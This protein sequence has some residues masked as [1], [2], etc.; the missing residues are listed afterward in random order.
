MLVPVTVTPVLFE[1]MNNVPP[2]TSPVVGP[3]CA[4]VTLATVAGIMLKARGSIGLWAPV[5]GI[6][7]GSLVAAAFGVYDTARVADAPWIGLPAAAWP[8]IHF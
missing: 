8:A 2:G 5:I 3:L 7:A 4:L 1:Q 6:V